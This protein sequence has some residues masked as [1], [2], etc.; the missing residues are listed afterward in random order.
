M[1]L[2]LRVFTAIL[3]KDLLIEVRAKEVLAPVATFALLMVLVFNFGFEIDTGRGR[4]VAPA[5]LWLAFIL[6]GLLGFGR[7]FQLEREQGALDAML[8]APVD[9]STVYLAK[10]AVNVIVLLGV[11]V[12]LVPA[13]GLL[14]DLPVLR[15]G[16]LLTLA[17][18]TIGYASL[19]TLYASGMANLRSREVALPLL[20]LPAMIPLVIAVVEAPSEA[21]GVSPA[22]GRPWWA[23]ILAF[24][25]VFVVLSAALFGSLVKDT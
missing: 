11:E 6:G 21:M 9:R 10:L 20:V 4:D 12:I 2:D 3:W 5:A 8:L 1:N 23:L 13:F 17:L 19:G 25:A 24:D 18:G 14:F 16:V 7:A 15:P 22:S